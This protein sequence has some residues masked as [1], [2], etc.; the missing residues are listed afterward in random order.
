[1]G[2]VAID[3]RQVSSTARGVRRGAAGGIAGRKCQAEEN[4]VGRLGRV[5]ARVAV[6]DEHSAGGVVQGAQSMRIPRV[7]AAA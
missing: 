2:G 7:A 3:G 4:V 6:G 1:M 5:R